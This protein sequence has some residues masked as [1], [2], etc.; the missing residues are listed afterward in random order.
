MLRRRT[1]DEVIAELAAAQH[2]VVARWQL[3]ERGLSAGEIVRR[4]RGARLHPVR[5]GW[6]GVYLAGHPVAPELALETAALLL[7][8]GRSSALGRWSAAAIHGFGD[9]RPAVHLLQVGGTAPAADGIRASVVAELPGWQVVRRRGVW[10]TTPARTFL[11]LSAVAPVGDV[12]RCLDR[13]RI[14]RVVTDAELERVLAWAG[15]RRG[16][17]P[18]ANLLANER[19]GGYSRSRAER[20]LRRLMTEAGLPVPVRNGTIAGRERDLAWCQAR[21]VVEFDG[22]RFHLTPAQW[23]RD[24][25]RDGELL[26]R[27]WRT[28]RVTWTMLCHRPYEVVARA[29]AILALAEAERS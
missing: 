6:A 1:A 20:R 25:D 11:D 18:L 5:P 12:E 26:A 23:E 28:F 13:A 22:R 4:R 24:R 9:Q 10:V 19:D 27:G 15:T 14:A 21:T 7:C 17:R 2:G 29:A 8:R 3:L 16:V